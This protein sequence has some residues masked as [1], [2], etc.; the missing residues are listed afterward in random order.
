MRALIFADLRRILRKKGFRRAAIFGAVVVL[1]GIFY[2]YAD[3]DWGSPAF[4]EQVRKLFNFIGILIP[5]L[6]IFVAVFSD[7]VSSRSMQSMIGRGISRT[8]IILCKVIDCAVLIVIVFIGATI[9]LLL[10]ETL[11]DAHCSGAQ[12]RV[13]LVYVWF[14]AIRLFGYLTFSMIVLFATYS[15]PLGLF[16][17][18]TFIYILRTLLAAFAPRV[19]DYTFSGLM[20]RAYQAVSIGGVPLLLFPAVI[21]YIGGAILLTCLV[22]QK[23]ELEF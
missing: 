11:L 10:L 8:R 19:Y 16:A 21:L 7:E 9:E 23:K 1:L 4:L 12:I 5:G 3:S 22:F 13:M 14:S 17:A 15:V 18:I 6:A 20:A 2:V